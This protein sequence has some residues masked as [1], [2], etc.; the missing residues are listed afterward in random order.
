MLAAV[1]NNSQAQVCHNLYPYAEGVV[2]DNNGH[3][4][5]GFIKKSRRDA[6]YKTGKIEEFSG[7]EWGYLQITNSRVPSIN[8][9]AGKEKRVVLNY[10]EYINATLAIGK[11]K[12]GL[13]ATWW[14]RQCNNP[15]GPLFWKNTGEEGKLGMESARYTDVTKALETKKFTLVEYNDTVY[16]RRDYDQLLSNYITAENGMVKDLGDYK[17][18]ILFY[19]QFLTKFT[20][21]DDPLVENKS[22]VTFVAGEKTKYFAYFNVENGKLSGH[23]E[24]ADLQ[25]EAD[26]DAL[27]NKTFKK[28]KGKTIYVYGDDIFGLEKTI[29]KYAHAHHDIKVVRR[30][31][32]TN[33]KF[34]NK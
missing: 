22:F 5:A 23:L 29:L 28:L 2:M 15:Q 6:E 13:R 24:I 10:A 34:N 4:L 9:I 1:T 32:D 33:D 7:G 26:R 12:D 11:S 25:Y 21:T 18:I 19:N 14:T 8:V 3:D 30:K 27:V 17:T 16:N 20:S 31:T